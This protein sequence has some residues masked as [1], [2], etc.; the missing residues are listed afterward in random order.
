[1]QNIPIPV[2]FP[3]P[4]DE[5]DFE[6]LCVDILRRYWKLPGLERYGSRGQRQNGVDILDLGGGTPLHAAQCKLRE[7]HKTLSP[8]EIDAEVTDALGF[9]F[10]I[11]KYGIL[12]TAKISTQA[13]RKILEIN[14][15]HR[16]R[17][18]FEVELLPWGKLCRLLQQ[19][20]DVRKAY[21]ELT[22]VTADSRV[23]SKSPFVRATMQQAAEAIVAPD[24]TAE[25]DEARDAINRRDFQVAL[26]LLNRIRQRYDLSNITIHD[27]FRISSNLAFAELGLRRPDVAA[28]HLLEAVGFEP[29]DE[30]ARTNEVFAYILKGQHEMA[31]AKA[32][33]LR[34]EYPNSKKLAANWVSS[35]PPSV[36]IEELEAQLSA[37][38]RSDGEVALAL[39]RRALLEMKI[40]VALT[41]ADAAARSLPESSHP[42]LLI[43]R[44]NLGWILQAG[45]GMSIPAI[46]RADL[47]A[48]VE[49]GISESITLA[50]A[51]HDPYTQSEAL[52]LRTD[53][54][55]VQKRFAEAEADANEALRL[56]PENIQPLLALSHLM[57]AAKRIDESIQ[58]LERAYRKGARPEAAFMY[59]GA[60]LQRNLN[61]DVDVA[62]SLLRSINLSGLRP[63]FRPSVIRTMVGALVR[64]AEFGGART[65]L[66]SITEGV[67]PVVVTVWRGHVAFDE[68][69]RGSAEA[70]AKQAVTEV[71]RD[72]VTE[73]KESL[74][75][76]LARL[77]MYSEALPLF[78]ELFNLNIEAFDPRQLLDCAARLHRDD[79]VMEVCAE[80]KRRGQDPWE[81][82]RFEVQF[83]QKY[84][85]EKAVARLD[86]FLGAHPGHKLATLTRSIIGVQSQQPALVV[87]RTDLL[88]SVEELP[89]EYITPTIHVLRFGG[90]GNETV[91]YAYRYLRLHFNDMRAH[92]ALMLSLMPGDP[93]ITIPPAQEA[94]EVGSA[95]AVYDDVNGVIRWFVL[96]ATD[97]PNADFEEISADSSLAQELVGKRVGETVVLAKGQMQSR[98]GTVRQIVPKYV[99]RFQDT[100]GEMQVRFGDKSIVEPIYFGATEEQA[101]TA[102][103]R[104]LDSV[105]HRRS[106]IDKIR[107]VYDEQPMSLH[108]FGDQ[109]G[110]NAYVALAS[111][112]QE[113]GQFVKCT[114]GTPEERAEGIF[115]LQTASH[116]VLDI[117]ALATVRLI[118]IETLLLGSK[119]FHYRISEGTFHELQETLVGDLFSGSTSGT[120]SHRDGVSSFTEE[121]VDQ[122]ADRKTKDQEFLDHLKAVVEIVPVMGLS[123][124]EP[125]RREPLEQMFGQYGAETMLLAAEP[126]SVLWTDDLI[127]AQLAKNEFGVKRAWTELVAEQA[128]LA[129]DLS[130]EERERV[131]ASLVSMEY[132]VTSFDST[133]MLK[134]AEMSDGTPWR[135]PLRQF[136]DIFRKPPGNFRQLLGIFLDFIVKL[137]RERYLPETKCRIMTA[138]MDA[139]WKN[140]PLRSTI[141]Q[142]RRMSGQIFGLNAVGQQQFESCFDKWYAGQADRLI[143]PQ[144]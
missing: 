5:D 47:E 53:L 132:L 80:L 143:A 19:Y 4:T 60:L 49:A 64:K 42:P 1:M 40:A 141:L 52:A 125:S 41:Y 109:F 14:Q 59:A 137:Y 11:G 127:E 89:L 23:G 129:G 72:T 103:Q 135:S 57:G 136:V 98:T 9:E 66:A 128:V 35:S 130:N 118:G 96:E 91:D 12:T 138:F 18:A 32:T 26:L 104:V 51:E 62:L 29:T 90:M 30:R 97:K 65:Y 79:V 85:R 61:D 58:L 21:F 31:Y 45:K 114:F 27:R 6:D 123:A 95:V 108:L 39:S 139:I 78:Q 121:T 94:V 140:V 93:S 134:A 3:I 63:E 101:A 15:R 77:G 119:R 82:V 36:T 69:D 16:A 2:L 92:Q 110:E 56:D 17:G 55:L 115:A 102:L 100:M 44:A 28:E 87:T 107:R 74:G 142:F 116:V 22:V 84:S 120:I 46:A 75:Q 43:A 106:A 113:G 25:I 81:V 126:D 37:E 20:D 10:K 117:T 88:P 7:Y 122:K 124:I 24:L 34:A 133:I 71:S 76:L 131:I 144:K 73:T 68:G 38:I 50:E 86:D 105:K 70:F 67:E 48:R 33:T 112:A 83:V 54:R 8:A 13:Q 111:L 99:R